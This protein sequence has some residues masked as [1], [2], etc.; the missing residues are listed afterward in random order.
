MADVKK[1]SKSLIVVA[2]IGLIGTLGTAFISNWDKFFPSPQ[3]PVSSNI[4]SQSSKEDKSMGGRESTTSSNFSTVEARREAEKVTAQWFESWQRGDVDVLVKL[5]SVPFFLDNEILISVSDVRDR[6]QALV[7]NK[8][9]VGKFRVDNIKSGTIA[10]YKRLGYVTTSD[11]LLSHMQLTDDDIVVLL[12]VST[13][14]LEGEGIGFY[15]RRLGDKV[16]MAGFWD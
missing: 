5:S 7:Q 6:Y 8:K 3:T 14:N 1:S 16:E 2:L 12:A 4:G 9:G 10:E 11:R 15:F 13:N